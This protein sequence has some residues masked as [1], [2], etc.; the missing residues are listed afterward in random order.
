MNQKLKAPWQRL[1]SQCPNDIDARFAPLTLVGKP[2]E[3]SGA[4]GLRQI[5]EQG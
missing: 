2:D 3:F 1:Y 4:L 5:I